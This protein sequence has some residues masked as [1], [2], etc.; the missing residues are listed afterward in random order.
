M[1]NIK[2]Y[3]SYFINTK[4]WRERNKVKTINELLK[5]NQETIKN[6]E[7]WEKSRKAEFLTNTQAKSLYNNNIK[8]L[9]ALLRKYKPKAKKQ[10]EERKEQAKKDYNDI[11]QLKDIKKATFE[12]VWNKNKG[13]YG[14]QCKC[15]SKIEYKNGSYNY[16][17]G[18]STSGCGYDKPSSALSYNMNK[19]CKILLLKYGKKILNDSEKHYN[20]YACENLYFSYGVGV[21]SYITMFKYFGFEVETI[22]HQNE[23]I[24]IMIKKGRK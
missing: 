1:E 22:Y 24:T 20:C 14:Y 17:E 6:M 2:N 10:L 4:T 23:D 7:D 15:Y 9:K 8:T 5:M 11:K 19:T 16:Y 13:V 3:Y 12:I 18:E 21:S